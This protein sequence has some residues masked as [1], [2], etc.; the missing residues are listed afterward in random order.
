MSSFF[1]INYENK[2]VGELELESRPRDPKS[3]MPTFTPFPDI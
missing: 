3:R 1:F 2:M